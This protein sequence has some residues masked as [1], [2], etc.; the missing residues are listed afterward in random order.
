[1]RGD[2]SGGSSKLQGNHTHRHCCSCCC[3]DFH[4]ADARSYITVWM[5]VQQERVLLLLHD[6]LVPP[7][8]ERTK[9]ERPTCL[10]RLAWHVRHVILTSVFHVTQ[11]EKHKKA[12]ALM[13]SI[14]ELPGAWT[15][16]QSCYR[17]VGVI[18]PGRSCK[19]L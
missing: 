16:A 11:H 12:P 17:E 18:L 8:C 4:A 5:Y 9:C 19:D 3:G 14:L 7:R 10:G 13:M 6:A 1:M 2:P 15:P